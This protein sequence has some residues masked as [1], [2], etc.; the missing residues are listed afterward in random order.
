MALVMTNSFLQYRFA[1][2][3]ETKL[4]ISFVDSVWVGGCVTFLTP[5]HV[6]NPSLSRIHNLEE[7]FV[8][9]R[10]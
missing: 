6:R 4:S 2:V 5:R 1:G 7:P 9:L 3:S 10:L 8:M